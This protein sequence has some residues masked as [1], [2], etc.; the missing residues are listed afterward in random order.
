VAAGAAVE[1]RWQTMRRARAN[2]TNTRAGEHSKLGGD[3][4]PVFGEYAQIPA[5][6]CGAFSN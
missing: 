5:R 6:H 4:D 2:E 3:S 1:L